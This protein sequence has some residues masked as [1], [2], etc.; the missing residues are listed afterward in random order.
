M[1]VTSLRFNITSSWDGGGLRS[2]SRALS[3]VDRDT[4][5][6]NQGLGRGLGGMLSWRNAALALAPAMFT[7][8]K[9]AL[10]LAGGLVTMGAAAAL[11]AAPWV[12]LAITAAR[13]ADEMGKAG[14]AYEKATGRVRDAW[15]D[16]AKRTA[17]L[18]LGPMTD[19][20]EGVANAIPKLEPLV[21]DIAPVFADMGR[22]IRDWLSG[23][24]FERFINNLRIAGV[25]A[26]RSLAG[27]ARDFLATAGIGFR[28]FLPM[29]QRLAENI[30]GG[31]ASM[32]RWAEG[33]GFT[34]FL[35]DVRREWPQ[36]RQFL[37][38][39]AESVGNIAG[40]LDQMGPGQLS[41]LSNV[42]EQF[43]KVDVDGWQ[44]F[45]LLLAGL[46]LSGGLLTLLGG[47]ANMRGGQLTVSGG[48]ALAGA[49]AGLSAAGALLNS[50]A[51]ALSAAASALAGAGLGAG[52]GGL[53]GGL[54]AR[55]AGGSATFNIT[56]NPADAAARLQAI[57]SAISSLSG[58]TATATVTLNAGG[59]TSGAQQVIGAW[60]AVR[61]A[62]ATPAVFRAMAIPGNVPVV[63][64]TLIATWARVRAA[65]AV[66]AIFRASAVPG[67]VA[68]VAATVIAAWARVRAAAAVP[69]IF[70]AMAIP[71]NVI[72]VAGA[73]IAA[74]AG[75]RAAAA[76]TVTFRA[77]ASVGSAVSGSNQA[78]SAWRRVLSMPRSWSAT[79]TVNSGGAVSGANAAVAAWSRVLAMPRSVTFTVNIVTKKSGNSEGGPPIPVPHLASGGRVFG[80]GGPRSD[81]IPA[82]L[83]RGEWVIRAAAVKALGTDFLSWVNSAGAGSSVRSGAGRV[84]GSSM[85]GGSSGGG[86]GKSST[87]VHFHG[88]V[89][90]KSS[91]E[92]EDMVVEAFQEAKRKGRRF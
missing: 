2:A 43:N 21:R 80:P 54:G 51:A 86:S 69:A 82:M 39:A 22:S 10:A 52:L 17:P 74:W 45:L 77:T 3:D 19:V 85:P 40:T 4:R 48:A 12:G 89:Y 64:A 11:A 81:K 34:R 23:S 26:F 44:D 83:S 9:H 72:G 55:L 15:M 8:G 53:L 20:L 38:E 42:L 41:G 25:P 27:A 73:L 36:V 92:F 1:P 14:V 18:T 56:I 65:A 87:H 88:A 7:L 46:K 90:A 16:L 50:A 13:N 35:A 78:A 33:G 84:S 59:F 91:M 67:N 47:L 63:A 79:A 71:G 70:R 58:R 28:A 61:G 32:R 37:R 60:A 76:G 68:G 62:A 57:S 75:V 5:R 24:G 30:E 31:A 6:V 29:A 66:P 49:A